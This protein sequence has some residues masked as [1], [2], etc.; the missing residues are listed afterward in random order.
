MKIGK[1]EPYLIQEKYSPSMQPLRKLI[2]KVSKNV[3]FLNNKYDE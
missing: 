2:L 1:I 3:Y